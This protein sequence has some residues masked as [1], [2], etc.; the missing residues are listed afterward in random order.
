MLIINNK[1]I[2]N[3]IQQEFLLTHLF[4]PKEGTTFGKKQLMM[5]MLLILLYSEPS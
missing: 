5:L 4:T 2:D 1:T 3:F